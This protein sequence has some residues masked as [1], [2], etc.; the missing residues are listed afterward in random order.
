MRNKITPVAAIATLALAACGGNSQTALEKVGK[1]CG[2]ESA[3][4]DG[5]KS[6]SLDTEGKE[7]GSGD[8]LIQVACVLKTTKAPNSVVERMDHTRA[9]DGTQTG[10]WDGYHATW[11]YHPDTG[12]F[13]LIEEA[14]S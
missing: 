11:S 8:T 13:L 6:L 14:K 3:V 2:V 5:G 7:D 1:T 12:M 10:D 9:L 4:D